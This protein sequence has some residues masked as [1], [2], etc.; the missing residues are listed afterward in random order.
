MPKIVPTPFQA[1]PWHGI[2]VHPLSPEFVHV[3]VEIVP[4]D[5]IKYEVDKASGHLKVD[6]PQAFSNVCPAIYGFIP[7]TYCG[8]GTAS[9]CMQATKKTG[10]QGDGDPLDI[11][12]FAEKAFSHGNLLLEAIAI[13]GFRMI[14]KGEADDKIIA[15]LKNDALYGG[16]RDI[17]D[18][19]EALIKRLK[20][21]FLTYKNAQDGAARVVSIDEIYGRQKAQ[22]VIAASHA[23]YVNVTTDAH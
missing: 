16:W 1:H 15:V 9:L 23:D 11:C 13:G 20:H 4:T 10:I 8:D 18:C 5:T 19:P 22:A 3:F 6:R 21:Y 7:R 2:A 14:D 17:A 12:V